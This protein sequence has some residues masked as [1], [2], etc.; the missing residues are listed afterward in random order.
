MGDSRKNKIKHTW[1]V[2][3]PCAGTGKPTGHKSYSSMKDKTLEKFLILDPGSE[4][5]FFFIL[6][7][8]QNFF[9]IPDPDN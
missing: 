1:P 4:S 8:N 7:F 2:G 5:N 3:F 6:I 9:L